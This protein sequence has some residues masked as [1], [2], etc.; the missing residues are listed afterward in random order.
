MSDT[1]TLAEVVGRSGYRQLRAIVKGAN[2]RIRSST[3]GELFLPIDHTDDNK[4][5]CV[6]CRG[7]DKI[8][9]RTCACYHCEFYCTGK[10]ADETIDD[11]DT[12]DE[13][14]DIQV[15]DRTDEEE[16]RPLPAPKRIRGYVRV[17]EH[18]AVCYEL[19]M[20]RD[21]YW[22]QQAELEK[23]RNK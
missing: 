6:V 12:D 21:V 13:E 9:D 10:W 23:L 15:L 7:C 8:D 2:G 20:M 5:A 18:T 19:Q 14:D 22:K 11:T 1:K 3:T 16:E 4:C 17:E